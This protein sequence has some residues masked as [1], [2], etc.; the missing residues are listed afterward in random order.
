MENEMD[1]PTPPGPSKN[2]KPQKQSLL[3]WIAIQFIPTIALLFLVFTAHQEIT[4]RLHATAILLVTYCF[5]SIVAFAFSRIRENEGTQSALV[6][7]L[8]GGFVVVV[9]NAIF[10]VSIL[11]VGCLCTVAGH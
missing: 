1:Q 11:F 10:L 4:R 9:L 8:I 5:G 7:A 2:P 3:P 6:Y